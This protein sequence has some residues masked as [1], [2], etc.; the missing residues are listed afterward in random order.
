MLHK[1]T[2]LC[3][4]FVLSPLEMQQKGGDFMLED[5]IAFF[6]SVMAS[7]VAYYI[8]KWFDGKH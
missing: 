4:I 6:F 5:I 7:I 3:I 1:L 2:T 8:C